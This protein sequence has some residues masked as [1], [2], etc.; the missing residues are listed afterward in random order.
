MVDAATDPPPG[1]MAEFADP[2]ALVAAVR[3]ARA[4][5]FSAVEAFTPWPVAELDQAL[6]LTDRRVPWLTLAGGLLGGA[7]GFGLPVVANLAF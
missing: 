4:A 5:G 1:V 7:V 2:Q 3:Q 6:G